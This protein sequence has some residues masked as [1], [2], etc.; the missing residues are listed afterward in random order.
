MDNIQKIK[1]HLSLSIQDSSPD[2]IWAQISAAMKVFELQFL[3]VHV[4]INVNP[5]VVTYPGRIGFAVG[6]F[7]CVPG[8]Y[9]SFVVSLIPEAIYNPNFEDED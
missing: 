9:N 7:G 3:E 5:Q 1:E 6:C 4:P 8:K 2:I